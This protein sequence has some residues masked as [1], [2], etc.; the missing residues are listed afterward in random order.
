MACACLLTVA[1]A[2]A[3]PPPPPLVTNGDFESSTLSPWLASNG[4][5]LADQSDWAAASGQQ[6]VE[7]YG[8]GQVMQDVSTTAGARYDLSFAYAGNPGCGQGVAHLTVGWNGTLFGPGAGSAT[9]TFDTTG[10]TTASMGWQTAHVLVDAASGTTGIGFSDSLDSTCGVVID[11]VVMTAASGTQTGTQLTAPTT[12]TVAGEPKTLTATVFAAS[13][14]STP[15]G[16]VQFEADGATLGDPVALSGGQAQVTVSDLTVG[17]HQFT[18]IYNPDSA[19]FAASAVTQPFWI[20]RDYSATD[21]SVGVSPAPLDQEVTL[22][23]TVNAVA[24]GDAVPTGTVQFSDEF[25]L[26]GEP[27]AVGSDG[28]AQIGVLEGVGDHSMCASYSGDA[29][30]IES[31]GCTTLTVFDPNPTPTPTPTGDKIATTVAMVSSKNPTSHGEPYTVTATVSA[32]AASDAALDGTIAFTVNAV[33]FG[34][35]V[36]LDANHSAS[37]TVT[38]P[39]GVTRQSIRARYSGN[40]S[41]LGSTASL[42]QRIGAL[43]TTPTGTTRPPPPDTQAPT[44]TMLVTPTRLAAALRRG[45]PVQIDCNENCSAGLR[46]TLAAR[47]AK[48]LGMRVRG[49][50]VLVAEAGYDFADRRHSDLVLRFT[51]RA[52]KALAKARRV[53]LRLTATAGDLSGNDAVHVKTLVLKR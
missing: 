35:P 50:T 25:G 51:R 49:K 34:D 53:A 6:S 21:L 19:S 44:F 23:A 32:N 22:T 10:R 14:G 16:T 9:F 42:T 29:N 4:V 40:A 47:Q 2:Q 41:F 1:S 3:V 46:L 24:P 18:A 11:N 5:T 38:P 43:T 28:T 8:Y 7:L 37:I 33:A 39:D 52:R 36:P 31:G 30:L 13:S 20:V 27:V 15:T 48:A 17:V 45:L 26:L 12:S